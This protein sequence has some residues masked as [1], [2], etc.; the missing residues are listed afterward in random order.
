M[1]YTLSR[2]ARGATLAW[3]LTGSVAGWAQ[4]H[5]PKDPPQVIFAS[6]LAVSPGQTATLQLRGLKLDEADRV[7]APGVEPAPEL[8]LKKK[9]KAGVPNQMTPQQVGDTLV[10][11]E[12]KTPEAF[13][14]GEIPLVVHTPAGATQP[15]RLLVVP[16]E[17]LVAEVEP[18][19]GFQQAQVVEPGKTVAGVIQ[20][21]DPEVF[22][23]AGKAGQR[24]TA[25]V[26][27]RRQGSPVD[28][29]LTLYDSAGRLLATCDD[30]ADSVDPMLQLTLPADGD[31]LI[32]LQDAH[33]RGGNTHPYLFRVRIE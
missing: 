6:A 24:L 33:D 11:I 30:V 12:L 32:V 9:E 29:I 8:T 1:N 7:E 14:G 17:Q 5:A 26:I 21:K 15:Y 19:D 23:V 16:G 10:E 3:L 2:A 13:A 20:P 25:E 31:Y 18:N 22:R 4:D 27:A 28:G